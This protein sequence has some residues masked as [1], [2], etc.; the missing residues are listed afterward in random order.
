MWELTRVSLLMTTDL[1]A[2]LWATSVS[3]QQR[4]GM[5]R[6]PSEIAGGGLTLTYADL[7]AWW[8]VGW[9]LLLGLLGAYRRRMRTHLW[10]QSGAILR[11]AVASLA[12][13]GIASMFARLQVSRGFVLTSLALVIVATLFGRAVVYCLL[14]SLRRKGIQAER[15][16]LLGSG[17]DT[18]ALRSHILR[19]S[20]AVRVVAQLDPAESTTPV[21]RVLCHMATGMGITAVVATGTR[22]DVSLRDLAAEIG[23]RGVSLLVAPEV[24][25]VLGPSLEIQSVGDL[26]LLR[27]GT[28]TRPAFQ[29]LVRQ[30][31]DRSVAGVLLVVL[32]PVLVSLAFLVG[33]DGGPALFRQ[34]RVG[35]GGRPFRI[36][37][38][39]TMRPDAEQ[40][41]HA[42]G[43]YDDYVSNGFKLPADRDPRITSIGRWLRR[44]SL[45]ELPQLWN[46]V[47]GDMSLV[48]PR[49]VVPAELANYDGMVRAYT[50]VRPGLTGYWQVSGRS[51]I[52]FP[53]RAVLDSY[54][55][56]HQT[57][58]MDLRIL[59]RTAVAVLKRTG[60]H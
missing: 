19:T 57:A 58:R 56:D 26:L 27:V 44:T 7:A 22:A 54:Y 10:G 40:A 13:L 31:F 41:L 24:R 9:L 37:K 33:R 49:P 11:A 1:C 34:T 35:R 17:P 28:G 3:R 38:F 25:E 60:A 39:R 4:F 20:R 29:R 48:G 30:L 6:L 55:Y 42:E 18:D 12:G 46:V 45:D 59:V 21:G 15:V 51:D 2:V 14:E 53:E 8:S 5:G 43:L 23:D 36:L 16:V 50:G 52:G 32:L 47:R